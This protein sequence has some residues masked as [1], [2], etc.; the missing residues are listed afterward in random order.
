MKRNKNSLTIFVSSKVSFSLAEFALIKEVSISAAFL[1]EMD[2]SFPISIISMN[3]DMVIK[4]EG[5][6]NQKNGKTLKTNK[7]KQN[8][9]TFIQKLIRV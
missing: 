6:L 7:N 2:F 8:S 3:C 1:L 5:K 4:M 9:K